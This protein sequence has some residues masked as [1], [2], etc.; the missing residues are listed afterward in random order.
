MLE[1]CWMSATYGLLSIVQN[2][3]DTAFYNNCTT[4]G[5]FS[6]C[7]IFWVSGILS[8][9]VVVRV[10]A[11]CS[12]PIHPVMY[13]AQKS[14][15]KNKLLIKKRTSKTLKWYLREDYSS[16]SIEKWKLCTCFLFC[17]QPFR[18]KECFPS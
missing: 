12:G 15:R 3:M 10:P 8:F 1:Q 17:F 2:L 14:N 7:N 9:S 6:S 18:Q 4:S 11:F 16:S 13:P 5:A